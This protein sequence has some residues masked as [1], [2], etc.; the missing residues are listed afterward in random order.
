MTEAGRSSPR[1]PWGPALPRGWQTAFDLGSAGLMAVVLAVVFATFRDYGV[2]WDETWHL[3]YGDHILSW[4]STGGDD[5]SA[6]CYR[7][8]YLYGGGFD[9]AGALLRRLSP[10]SDFETIHLFGALIGVL[11]LWGVHRLG[12]RL[13][14][15]A[16]GFIAV[17]LLATTP[18]YY[19]HMFANPK[20]LPFAVGYVWALDALVELLQHQPRVPRRV[21]IRFAV[22]AGLAMG[23]RIAGILLLVYLGSTVVGLAWLRARRTRSLDAGIATARRL[24]RP[25]ALSMLGAWVVMLSTW[26]WALLDPVRRPWM[27]L[28]RMSRFTVHTRTMPFA[29]Q[30]ML[31]TEPRWDYLLHYFGLKL[32][33]PVLVLVVTGIV[34]MV[35]A[36]RRAGGLDGI[37]RVRRNVVLV[38]G[39]AILA[40]PAYAVVVQSVVY[41]G[42]RHFL[43]LVPPIVVVAAVTA[44]V[45]PRL[46]MRARVAVVAV[47]A[48]SLTGMLAR[49]V[50]AMVQLHPYQYIYFNE[51][52]GGLRGASGNYDTDYY[53][54]SYK[55]GFR[56]LQEHLWEVDR[57][58]FL[59]RRYTVAGCIPE[60][61]AR[62]YIEGG[63]VWV[64][65]AADYPRF[66]LGYTRS[67]CHLRFDAAPETLRVERMDSV[68]L[69]VRDLE[70]GREKLPPPLRPRPS[71]P[72]DSSP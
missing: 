6:L 71:S 5:T 40:P 30:D 56:A 1:P 8:D 29:G 68:L 62:N 53:G 58:R 19:G 55:E 70:K 43:F 63:L 13:A 21:W 20:D 38:M 31:T 10:M 26:P 39:A 41:D 18:V 44:V 37:S 7:I 25:A 65:K 27:A 12:S 69:L 61:V 42:L 32:P 14:G 59:D 23:V 22:L 60:L 3:V 67:D 47:L 48:L 24:G 4:F 36:L 9:L 16:A 28:G 49:Q 51:L 2:T 15:P 35:W 57:E 46:V 34:L 11:G 52:I 66:Y 72:P 50:Q 33:L 54:A 45:L 17:A 64:D